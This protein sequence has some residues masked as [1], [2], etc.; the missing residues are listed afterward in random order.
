MT[1]LLWVN[2]YAWRS[3]PFDEFARSFKRSAHPAIGANLGL[4]GLFDAMEAA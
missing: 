1:V 4:V 2:G 3:C